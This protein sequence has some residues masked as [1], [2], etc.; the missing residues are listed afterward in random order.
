[1]EAVENGNEDVVDP[2]LEWG[3]DLPIRTDQGWTVFLLAE[4]AFYLEPS[5]S[6]I[7]KLKRAAPAKLYQEFL[8]ERDEVLYNVDKE[9][10]REGPGVEAPSKARIYIGHDGDVRHVQTSG[11]EQS[12]L[13]WPM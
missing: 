2:L 3:A 5:A 10:Q 6:V 8:Q 1:M 12:Q 9:R 4:D 13:Y 7:E 11:S